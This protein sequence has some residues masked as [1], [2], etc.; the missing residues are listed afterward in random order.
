[1]FPSQVRDG[2]P[3]AVAGTKTDDAPQRVKEAP[4]GFKEM[5]HLEIKVP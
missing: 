4:A 5:N 3:H 1:M 2:S